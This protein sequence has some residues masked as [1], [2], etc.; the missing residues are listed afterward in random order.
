MKHLEGGTGFVFCERCKT[1]FL[2]LRGAS[3]VHLCEL[4]GQRSADQI[5]KKDDVRYARRVK[6]WS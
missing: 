5:E 4:N 3:L 6:D 1:L 2:G